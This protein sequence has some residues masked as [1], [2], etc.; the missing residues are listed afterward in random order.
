MS[1]AARWLMTIANPDLPYRL[2]IDAPLNPFDRA[3]FYGGGP[4]GYTDYPALAPGQAVH[5]A[6]ELR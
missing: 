3:T 1:R 6:L 4:Q 2:A 5:G